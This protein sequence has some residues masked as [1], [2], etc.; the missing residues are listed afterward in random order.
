MQGYDQDM[1][2]SIP[3]YHYDQYIII[4]AVQI[5]TLISNA[6]SFTYVPFFLLC[7]IFHNSSN[8]LTSLNFLYVQQ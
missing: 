3:T 5:L 8:I 7:V 6:S 2:A 1:Y 4:K